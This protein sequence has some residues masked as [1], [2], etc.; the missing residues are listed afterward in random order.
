MKSLYKREKVT[1]EELP[2]EAKQIAQ[3]IHPF[4]ILLLIGQMGSG[5]TT[6]TK[7]FCAALGVSDP[8]SSPTFSLVNEYE[9]KNGGLIYHFDLYR[10]K[11]SEELDEIGFADYL[12]SGNLCIIEWPDLIYPYLADNYCE[13][14][15]LEADSPLHRTI[16]VYSH[17]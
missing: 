17:G 10:V 4:R 12:D 15:L 13:I 11:N 2:T 1:L 6:F 5:K 9:A 3:T 7:A 8:V 16:Q 14:H